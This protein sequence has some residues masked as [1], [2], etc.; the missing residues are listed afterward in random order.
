[1]NTTISYL[2][3][4]TEG[5]L[6]FFSPC[7][8]PVLPVLL[9]Y[10]G[11]DAG[12]QDQKGRRWHTFWTVLLFV[13]GICTVY[14]LMALA[15]TALSRFI[16]A[17]RLVFQI[18]GG[19]LLLFFGLFAFG[20]IQIPF[21]EQEHRLQTRAHRVR[22]GL[23]A[24]LLGF[25]FSFAWTPCNG[26]YLASAIILAAGSETRAQG[27][28]CL[29]IYC[30]GFVIMFLLIGLFTEEIL[31]FLK[32][33]QKAVRWAQKIGGV[34]LM[35]LGC[36]MI[37]TA[38]QKTDSTSAAASETV[39]TE[40]TTEYLTHS[41]SLPDG[42]GQIVDMAD[43]AGQTV[44]VNFF[45]TWCHY[46]NQFLPILQEVQDTYA[47]VKVI[48]IAAPELGSEGTIDEIQSY[49]DERGYDMLILYDTDYSMTQHYGINGYPYTFL[50]QPD[51]KLYGYVPGYVEKEQ[52]FSYVEAAASNAAG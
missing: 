22:S 45:G 13:L 40:T 32:K 10:L 9:G 30:L 1:M 47:D 41:F 14:V 43:Y 27:F 6:S 12:Q 5:L 38:G 39:Q 36:W 49:M 20:V 37:A 4:F 34:L 18:V 44:I 11:I 24:Y 42:Q 51:G 48:L 50:F 25:F 28:A 23:E 35:V 16:Q 2:S 19:C 46:C 17:H 33:N 15:S 52:F 29:G 8:L 7:V 31:A 21:L 3:L 26:P